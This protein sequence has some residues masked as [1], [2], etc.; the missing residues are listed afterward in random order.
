MSD[1]KD[2]AQKKAIKEWMD[3][4]IFKKIQDKLAQV[5]YVKRV[6]GDLTFPS[7]NHTCYQSYNSTNLRSQVTFSKTS[8]PMTDIVIK[9]TANYLP[10]M[11][12]KFSTFGDACAL[13]LGSFRPVSGKLNVNLYNFVSKT[14]TTFNSSADTAFRREVRYI[15]LQEIMHALGF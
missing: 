7:V 10:T 12:D 4:E 3:A 11:P 2:P 9:V 15:V 14:N 13:D 6:K 1:F 5:L 8:F